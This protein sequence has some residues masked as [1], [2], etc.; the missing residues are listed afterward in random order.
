MECTQQYV[1]T[2]DGTSF[3][4]VKPNM[5]RVEEQHRY[6]Y[7]RQSDMRNVEDAIVPSPNRLQC[8][9]S[10]S[11]E[12]EDADDAAYDIEFLKLRG[13]K[14]LLDEEVEVERRV[15]LQHV[16]NDSTE[17]LVVGVERLVGSTG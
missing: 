17:E 12:A 4:E 8:T 1:K 9:C 14:T 3:V 7:H 10:D 11:S 2:V 15:D 5:G 16:D 13:K 6:P